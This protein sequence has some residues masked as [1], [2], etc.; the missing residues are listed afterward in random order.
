[1]D[2]PIALQKPTRLEQAQSRIDSA[3]TALE[4]AVANAPNI[5]A[6]EN[7]TQLTLELEQECA[8]L[9]NRNET[10]IELNVRIVTRL[11]GVIARLK[12]VADA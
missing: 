8:A 7:S 3:F 9:K 10:L 4:Q 1:M 12:A 11:D 6:A 2:Q 5:S